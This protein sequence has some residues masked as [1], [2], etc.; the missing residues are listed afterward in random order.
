MEKDV[1]IQEIMWEYNYT[2]QKATEI[3]NMYIKAGKYNDLCELVITKKN[4]SVEV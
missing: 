2:Q 3:V 1:L 4:L